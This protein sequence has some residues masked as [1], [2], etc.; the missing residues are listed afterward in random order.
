MGT[1]PSSFL[2]TENRSER[3]RSTAYRLTFFETVRYPL[4]WI[5]LATLPFFVTG[6]NRPA[7]NDGEGMY[8]EIAREM[9]LDGDWVTPHLN[10]KRHFD[11]PPLPYWAIAINQ[12]LLGETE[13]AARLWPALATWATVPVVGALGSTLYGIGVGCLA[14][15]VFS[16]FT[17]IFI[18]GRM[19]MPDPFLYFWISLAILG[20]I[21]GYV[22][23]QEP[24]GPWFWIMFAALGMAALTKSILGMGLPTA[25]IMLHVVVSGRLRSFLSKRLLAGLC[26]TAAVA[27]PWLL[28][29]AAANPDFLGYFIIR[30]H[31]LRF[32]GQR[33]PPDEF[34]SLPIFFLL[35]WVW[36]FPWM[37]FVPQALWKGWKRM[38]LKGIQDSEETILFLWIVLIVGLFTASRSRLEYY[39][40][41]SL[42]AFAIL[43][44]K[45]WGEVLGIDKERGSLKGMSIAMAIQAVI[46][47]CV[48]LGAFAVLGPYK[49]VVFRAIQEAWPMAGWVVGPDQVAVLD[50]IRVPSLVTVGALAV[51]LL[52]ALAAM[53]RSRPWFCLGILAGM[54][55]PLFVMIHWG[56]LVME[57]F[58]SIRPVA[59][60]V[61][62]NTG[63]DD[64][65][66]FQEPHEFMWVG[67]LAY[68]T[69][70]LVHI[71]R[72]PLFDGLESRKREP[73][74]RFLDQSQLLGLW[75]SGKKV[76]V[77]GYE[78]G[79]LARM[80]PRERQVRILG[81]KGGRVVMSNEASLRKAAGEG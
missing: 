53:R 7:L 3:G 80:L 59:E 20:Y 32:T 5:A 10:G 64:I 45:L 13:L 78:V 18:F 24:G 41:P 25:I 28:A 30:E 63:P 14:A 48:A 71:Y 16:T 55:L 70:R 40:L 19:I 49:D 12:T 8:A 62:E 22:K 39:A 65:V 61:R 17:G 52:G 37:S 57:P 43:V 50:H 79:D 36:M 77:V 73:P 68:Y 31:I 4:L 74:E 11:K 33:F 42:P 46:M 21:K 15:L 56:F 35:T 44:G 27:L 58:M 38:R 26:V 69:K 29:V 81:V 2:D 23:N 1:D 72:N 6:L 75:D 76:V 51:L 34:L 47:A 60:I 9:R 67:G 54:M 66:V